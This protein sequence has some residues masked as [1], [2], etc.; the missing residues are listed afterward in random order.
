MRFLLALLIP[1]VG[2]VL[3]ENHPDQVTSLPGYD[4][5]LPSN[6]YSGFLDYE[7]DGHQIHTHYILVEA[8]NT[9]P[10]GTTPTPLIYWSNGGPGASSMFG[11][12]TEVGPLLLSDESLKTDAYRETNLPTLMY[13]TK[14]W[15]RLGHLLI[16]DAPAPVGYSH[17]ND[18]PESTQCLSWTDEL[19]SQNTYLALQT[20]FLKKFPV[21]QEAPLYLSGES[22]AG[23][24]IPTLA[25]RIVEGEF[26]LNLKG[27]AVGDGCLGTETGICGSLSPGSRIDYWLLL[28]LAGHAQ[29]P[30]STFRMVV[31]VCQ[32]SET[33]GFTATHEDACQEALEKLETQVGGFYEYNLY[34]DCGARNGLLGGA[35]NDYPCGGGPV[36]DDW[37]KLAQVK[38]ALNV[39]D[40]TFFSVDNAENFDYTPTEKDL[41]G[42][43]KSQ[44]G[45][46]QMLV[47]NGR[48]RVSSL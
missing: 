40:A 13:N 14:S 1:L 31:N 28:F 11:L 5:P 15:T 9:R 37:V 44:L 27:F 19:A 35:E 21:L 23:I 25:R 33:L 46:L 18:D 26:V 38:K 45:K 36:M 22:Y 34:D 17:C 6:W 16:F 3:V 7:L 39:P 29:I 32:G 2:A 43:Y 47:Y 4:A 41:T 12:M 10:H 8:E 24:Y 48:S 20:L 42:F 30:L